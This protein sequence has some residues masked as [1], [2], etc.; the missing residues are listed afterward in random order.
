MLAPPCLRFDP[1]EV[2]DDDDDVAEVDGAAVVED[3]RP[4][5]PPHPPRPLALAVCGG[6][7]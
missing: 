1:S 7:L 2:D 4:R 5:L 3:A 6:I